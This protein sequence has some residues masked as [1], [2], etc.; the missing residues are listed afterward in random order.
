M[1]AA[2]RSQISSG[3]VSAASVLDEPYNRRGYRPF[4]IESGK[5]SRQAQ[6]LFDELESSVEHGLDPS[7]YGLEDMRH[8]AGRAESADDLA[9]L[10]IDVSRAFIDYASD[11]GEGRSTGLENLR[12]PYAAQDEAFRADTLMTPLGAEPVDDL[13]RGLAPQHDAYRSLQ[14]E[15]ERY[16]DIVANGGWP[17]LPET[18]VLEPGDT[19]AA[20]GDIAE[21]LAAGG[22]LERADVDTVY[23]ERI[24]AAVR[25]FQ[26]ANG[27]EQDSL[28]GPNTRRA[29]NVS[30]RERLVDIKIN[31]ERWRR[32]PY[33]PNSRHVRVN[34]PAF[35]L[36]AYADGEQA[37]RMKIIAGETVNGR[38]TP[39]FTE[40]ME[41]VVFGPYW[42]IPESIARDEVVPKVRE[43]DEFM[44][45]N[46]YE[47][48]R[49]F[50]AD[51]EVLEPSD[52]NLD[53]VEQ[54][55]LKMRQAPGPG[56]ALGRVKFIFP[57][58][59]S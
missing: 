46:A 45:S 1:T 42:N 27:L 8:A 3:R 16:R 17:R 9:R 38:S 33:D 52:D 55:E 47:I 39:V 43:S 53:R 40:T 24:A 56:N 23:S 4:W 29:M 12:D 31:L 22:F 5:F 59:F 41:Y 28:Y 25:A 14:A 19:A 30:A 34:I 32:L 15:L 10:D 18:D 49:E 21:R 35:R 11:L 36:E 48:V 6:L 54:G 51:A 50:G 7:F 13:L 57:N 37:A 2:L 20:V 44:S 58:Q 26:D